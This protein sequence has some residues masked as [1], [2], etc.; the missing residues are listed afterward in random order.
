MAISRQPWKL[1]ENDDGQLMIY[2]ADG[3]EIA[4]VFGQEADDGA[5]L[6]AASNALGLLYVLH[7]MF[8]D[9]TDKDAEGGDN[10]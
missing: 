9:I 6:V 7:G 8:H 10:A 5:W 3:N 2:D 4:Q 1:E